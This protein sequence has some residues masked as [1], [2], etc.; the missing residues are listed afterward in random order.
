MLLLATLGPPS[1]MTLVP[2]A[3]CTAAGCALFLL[4]CFFPRGYNSISV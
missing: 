3:T 4:F 1:F 2:F